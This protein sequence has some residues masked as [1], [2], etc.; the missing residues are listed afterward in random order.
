MWYD[1]SCSQLCNSEVTFNE[2]G[3]TTSD[4]CSNRRNRC[5]AVTF[6]SEITVQ[7]HQF[8]HCGE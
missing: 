7:S 4:I 8:F 3:K 6:M 2:D 5:E 1:F